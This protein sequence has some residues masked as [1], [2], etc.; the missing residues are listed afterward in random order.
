VHH[1]P[2]SAKELPEFIEAMDHY[3]GRRPTVIAAQLL[4]LTVVRKSELTRARWSELEL[5]TQEPLWRIP[6]ER[7]KARV[8]HLVPLSRQAAELFAELKPISCG[9]EFVFPNI[10]RLDKPM[11]SSTLN[12]MFD[13]LKLDVT[14]H[15]MRAT[16]STLLNE[17]GMFRGDVI[18]RALAHA[19]RNR[20]RASYNA[21][22]YLPERRA[23]LEW[24][25]RYL[26]GLR[27]G[28][29]VIAIKRAA[30]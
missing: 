30:A 16:A 24:W 5:G 14:P 21:A 17:S 10:G 29:Y 19:E 18:E 4:L 13:R 22:E 20:M 2:L 3:V 8:E 9:S 15:A 23:M 12:F 11:S 6:G 28:G 7:M 25:A 1:R 26:D 27:A